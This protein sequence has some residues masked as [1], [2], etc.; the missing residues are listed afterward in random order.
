MKQILSLKTQGM[1]SEKS[2]SSFH[3]LGLYLATW[4]MTFHVQNEE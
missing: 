4:A 2:M 1:K 3:G